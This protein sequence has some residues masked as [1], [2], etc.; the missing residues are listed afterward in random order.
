MGEPCQSSLRVRVGCRR[1][2]RKHEFLS[3]AVANCQTSKCWRL[4]GGT[5]NPHLRKSGQANRRSSAVQP[6]SAQQFLLWH[7]SRAHLRQALK[8]RSRIICQDD[9]SFA[10]LSG[11]KPAIL[12]SQ[13]DRSS[14]YSRLFCEIID[15][16]TEFLPGGRGRSHGGAGLQADTGECARRLVPKLRPIRNSPVRVVNRFPP[17]VNR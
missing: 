6:R 11:S 5:G 17:R 1:L 12:D 7:T 3:F 16:P 10:E 14:A 2:G 9:G 8:K 15:M 4:S 13:V